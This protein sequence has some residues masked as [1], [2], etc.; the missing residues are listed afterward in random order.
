MEAS[1]QFVIAGRD[2]PQLLEPANAALYGIALSILRLV[3]PIRQAGARL[4]T[5]ITPRNDRL[6][7][8]ASAVMAQSIT[9]IAFVRHHIAATLARPS[10]RPGQADTLKGGDKMA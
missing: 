9:I 8:M 2:A 4:T 5:H 1:G 3:E 6:Y 10:T 7:M